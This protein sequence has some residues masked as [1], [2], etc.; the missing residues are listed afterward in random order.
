MIHSEDFYINGRKLIRTFS[1]TYYIEK[2][3]VLYEDAVD[4]E[5]NNY[6][7]TDQVLIK[8]T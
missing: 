3:G 4:V 7:E 2:D 1:D 5:K 6:T 8:H